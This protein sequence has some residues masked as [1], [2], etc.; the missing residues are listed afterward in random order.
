MYFTKIW[1]N[2]LPQ[3]PLI[4]GTIEEAF[5]SESFKNTKF[6]DLSSSSK[7]LWIKG[8]WGRMN[9]FLDLKN[10]SQDGS[11]AL[12]PKSFRPKFIENDPYKVWPKMHIYT[13]KC[14]K[15]KFL[16]IFKIQIFKKFI[17]SKNFYLLQ[18]PSKIDSG[19]PWSSKNM[20]QIAETHFHATNIHC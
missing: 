12:F 17:F 6:F 16:K 14:K 2:L 19:G 9:I 20:W 1:K 13:K 15:I 11:N 8:N 3:S 4:S 7:L 18:N 5:L 10:L